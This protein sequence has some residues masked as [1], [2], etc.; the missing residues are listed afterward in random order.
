MLRRASSA[1]NSLSVAKLPKIMSTCLRERPGFGDDSR[2]YLISLCLAD[3][4]LRG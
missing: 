3:A 4:I 1:E 2:R